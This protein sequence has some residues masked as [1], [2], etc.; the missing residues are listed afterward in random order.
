MLCW[1]WSWESHS[2]KLTGASGVAAAWL[3]VRDYP[4]PAR[5]PGGSPRRTSMTG[6]IET[7]GQTL[8]LY[9]GV[10]GLCNWLVRF[11]LRRDRH[12][13]F[14]FAPLQS[15]FAQELLRRHGLDTSDL[16]TVVVLADF[17]LSSERALTRSDAALWSVRQLGG[18]WRA[19]SVAKILPRS[20]R[21]AAYRLT[22]RYRYR[23][24][25]RYD[26]CPLPRAQDRPKFLG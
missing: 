16:D 22:A 21:E 12:D 19:F 26:A 8:V 1:D 2:R 17:G 25:G 3:P 14:R 11:L 6:E 15:E 10:C 23:V 7:T 13:H 20:L 18:P 24:F 5:A 9:D 4:E